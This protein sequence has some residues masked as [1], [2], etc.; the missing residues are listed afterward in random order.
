MRD[1]CTGLTTEE[2][3]RLCDRSYEQGAVDMK[4]K[5]VAWLRSRGVLSTETGRGS[6]ATN[7]Y[8]LDAADAI[9]RGE[10][11]K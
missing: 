9:E 4:A 6:Y 10:V 2:T 11:D 3:G 1:R 5:I 7:S 8:I